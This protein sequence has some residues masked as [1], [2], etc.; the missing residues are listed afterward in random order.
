MKYVPLS[1]DKVSQFLTISDMIKVGYSS[2]MSNKSCNST[3]PEKRSTGAI[4]ANWLIE[5]LR[6]RELNLEHAF[7]ALLGE[8]PLSNGFLA[9]EYYNTLFEW[10]A[11]QLDDDCLGIH[12]A[13]QLDL[14][15]W[16][17]FGYLLLNSATLEDWC[18]FGERYLSIFQRGASLH[19][20]SLGGICRCRYHLFAPEVPSRRQD[21]E[22]SLAIPV[23]F[24]RRH[25]GPQWTPDI[26]YFEHPQPQDL[27]CHHTIFG[28]NLRFNCDFNGFDFDTEVLQ[29]KVSDADPQL[30]EVLKS[31]A[32]HLLSQ[33]EQ[34][35]D[36]IK[37]VRLL[38]TAS[39]GGEYM[40]AE[41][42]ARQLNMTSRTLHRHLGT[43][44]TSYQQLRNEV[45]VDTAKEALTNTNASITEIS[46]KLG[47]SE[48]SAFVRAFKRLTGL[49]PLQ[50]R[51]KHG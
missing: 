25:L 44:N 45:V 18:R 10:G 36:L 8:S 32:N 40:G 20:N 51:K 46:T 49:S 2:E 3:K 22:F 12:I 23:L 11:T 50:Y 24:F 5:A 48:I 41:E 38:I 15:T 16:G 30:L 31:Q 28:E 39:L 33:I 13:E 34:K 27:S 26:A 35:P 4:A 1:L 6:Q 47:Y 21:V 17:I 29:T 7:P 19:Y 9:W 14:A 42:L 37:H 43:C